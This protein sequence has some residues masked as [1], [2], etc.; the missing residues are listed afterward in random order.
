M[1][2]ADNAATSKLDEKAFDAMKKYLI[3]DYGNAS[4]P[5]SFSASAKEAIKNSRII[6][7]SAIGAEPDEICFTSC[8]TESDNWALTKGSMSGEIITSTIEHHAVLKT[9]REL[10]K[11]GQIVKYVPVDCKGIVDLDSLKQLVSQKTKLVSIMFANN[12]IGT[13]EPVCEISRIAHEHGALFHSDA[14]QA[15]GHIN[16]DVK[17]MGIDLLSASAHKF[18]GPKGIGFLYIRKG[19]NISPFIFGGSQEYNKRAG[20][21]NVAS[22]VGM[23]IALNNNIMDIVKNANHLQAL[24]E[25]VTEIL[26]KSCVEYIRNGSENRIPG[27]M[28]LSFKNC[29]GEAI[30]HMM[31]LKGIC[32]STGSACDSK[33][34]QVSHVIK[35]INVP[36]KFAEGTIRIAFGKYNTKEDAVQIGKTLVSVVKQMQND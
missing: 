26:N 29:E 16:I 27:N 6:I 1:I 33:R 15:V 5:Y 2:Y 13:I 17:R 23:G 11:H 8:G 12:E 36:A 35:A 31:D 3:N 25:I 21:E 4:Q 9:C 22:I 19:I 34:T 18:N 24:E 28:S 7:A 30:L 10:E 32:I 20:T 14:V